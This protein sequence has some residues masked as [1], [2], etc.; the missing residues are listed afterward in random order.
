M[1][2]CLELC[3]GTK[4]VGKVFEFHGWE[5][6]S[7]DTEKRFKPTILSSILDLPDDIG[8]GFDFIWAS[9]PCKIFS[10]ANNSE[11][12]LVGASELVLKCLKIIQNSGPKTLWC[13]ENPST[14]L[15]K[16]MPFMQGLDSCVVSYCKYSE[17]DWGKYRKNTQLWNNV[18]LHLLKCK[19]DCV[20]CYKENG[21]WR[22]ID[23]AQH[24]C[25]AQGRTFT[26][27]ELYRIPPKL[28]E[29]IYEAISS[30]VR[31]ES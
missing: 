6:V 19:Y 26:T 9:P 7:V 23:H 16:T 27:T 12:D 30:R 20:H 15:L 1:K 29:A 14:G 31:M 18:D 8:K 17:G 25:K 2:K 24:G 3:C 10:I 4:S 11:R 22:H 13:L 5:V 21:R 28:I